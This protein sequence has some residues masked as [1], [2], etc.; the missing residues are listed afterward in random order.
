MHGLEKETTPVAPISAHP[1]QSSKPVKG[2]FPCRC[3]PSS[4]PGPLSC[5]SCC[6]A[7]SQEASGFLLPVLP[8]PQ[9][10]GATGRTR[11]DARR[12]RCLRGCRVHTRQALTCGG[13]CQSQ[14][15]SWQGRGSAPFSA[16]TWS[17]GPE[18][19]RGESGCQLLAKASGWLH[20]PQALRLSLSCLLPL[21]AGSFPERNVCPPCQP[22]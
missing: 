5:A 12:P 1:A 15:C 18:P 11:G 16:L 21:P 20:L 8:D 7:G 2:E 4:C 22:R 19:P 6:P 14:E 13:G 3:P 9:S 10:R 17:P